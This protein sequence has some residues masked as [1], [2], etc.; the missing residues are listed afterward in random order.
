MKVPRYPFLLLPLLYCAKN[1]VVPDLS[2]V[3]MK[4]RRK[5]LNR[6]RKYLSKRNLES[7][8]VVIDPF[9]WADARMESNADA[10]I[11]LFEVVSPLQTVKGSEG[12]FIGNFLAHRCLTSHA[13]R[14]YN[15]KIIK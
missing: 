14:I 9:V 8:L 3:E 10:V 12:L 11:Q 13:V 15:N 7:K 5:E 2:L 1:I 6:F 4:D